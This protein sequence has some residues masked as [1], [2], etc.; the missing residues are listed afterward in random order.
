MKFDICW[1]LFVILIVLVIVFITKTYSSVD[2][3]QLLRINDSAKIKNDKDVTDI[4]SQELS[5]PMRMFNCGILSLGDKKFLLT[6]RV[7]NATYGDGIIKSKPYYSE[8]VYSIT[9][10]DDTNRVW[11]R[12]SLPREFYTSKDVQGLEDARPFLISGEV[13]I[14][15][16]VHFEDVPQMV[17]FPLLD[18][19]HY[20]HLKYQTNI[21]QKNWAPITIGDKFYFI[22]DV[23]PSFT[24]LEI[25]DGDIV[26]AY[27]TPSPS[28]NDLDNSVIRAGKFLFETKKEYIGVANVKPFQNQYYIIFFSFDKTPP[29]SIR[30]W[31]KIYYCDLGNHFTYL[32]DVCEKNDNILFSWNLDDYSTVLTS[33]PKRE[34]QSFFKRS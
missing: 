10:K 9:S 6:S 28:I 23:Y 31:S 17:I 3:F 7:S 34:I 21:P 4:V 18:P 26:K 2:S 11:N 30:Q 20:L 22:Y 25:K 13:Y 15:G 12:L 16:T 33:L 1:V 8:F 5:I 14:L 29:H 19:S 24:L 27:S 32:F